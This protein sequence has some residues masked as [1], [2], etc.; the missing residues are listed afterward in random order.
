MKKTIRGFFVFFICLLW[1]I[2]INPSC[3]IAQSVEVTV[4]KSQDIGVYDIF[5][6]G[7]RKQLERAGYAVEWSYYDMQGDD[8]RGMRL[9]REIRASKRSARRL[10]R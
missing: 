4:L 6:D 10:R 2:G 5:L 7:C 8:A 1:C 3:S 9:A